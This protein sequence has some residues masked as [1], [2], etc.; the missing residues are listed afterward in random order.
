M[1]IKLVEEVLRGVVHPVKERDV[2]DLGMVEDL[3]FED[4][5]IG[6]AHV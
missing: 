3:K 5:Q 2:V 1:D 6:R 4:G